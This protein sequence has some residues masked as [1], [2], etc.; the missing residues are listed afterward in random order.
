VTLQTLLS[1]GMNN[2][3]AIMP[4][5]QAGHPEFRARYMTEAKWLIYHGKVFCFDYIN[6]LGYYARSPNSKY[7]KNEVRGIHLDIGPE[8]ATLS[9]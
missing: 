2:F 9:P 7:S 4:A 6:I 3:F 8:T 1:R 5:I